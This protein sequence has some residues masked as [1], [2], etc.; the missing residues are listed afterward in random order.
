[1]NDDRLCCSVYQSESGWQLRVESDTAVIMTEPFELQPRA[2]ARSHALRD[3]L[4][5][6]GWRES[7]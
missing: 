1:M 2:V 3:S 6:R 4:K 7:L 5:R